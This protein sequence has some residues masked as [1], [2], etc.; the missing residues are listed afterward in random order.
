MCIC[1]AYL[2]FL[3]IPLI[4]GNNTSTSINMI[5]SNITTATSK[6]GSNSNET[7]LLMLSEGGAVL[8]KLPLLSLPKENH[9]NLIILDKEI[10]KPKE[11]SIV[12]RKG[13][14]YNPLEDSSIST[15]NSRK[16]RIDTTVTNTSIGNETVTTTKM[17]KSKSMES[18]SNGKLLNTTFSNITIESKPVRKPLILSY[19]SH[20]EKNVEIMK[21]KIETSSKSIVTDQLPSPN[22]KVQTSTNRHPGM[23]MPVVITMLVVPMFAVLG[24]L[25]LRRGQ[26]A[27]KNRHYKRMDFLLDGMYND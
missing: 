3:F 4:T 11:K 19:E 15:N 18:A 21:S 23:V 1:S 7:K 6:S 20:G 13:V 27:W 8:P 25:A 26:E 22:V 9:T 24:Y 5:V 16:D 10:G 14:V 12:P 2:F 17:H